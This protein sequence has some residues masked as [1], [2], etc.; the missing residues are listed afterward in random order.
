MGGCVLIIGDKNA[1]IND[2]Q[3]ILTEINENGVM[4]DVLT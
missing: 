4:I 2:P 1:K 3:L